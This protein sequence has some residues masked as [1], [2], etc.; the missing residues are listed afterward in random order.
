MKT[1]QPV[2]TDILQIFS[3]ETLKKLDAE[4]FV[5]PAVGNWGPDRVVTLRAQDT[6]VK[7][8]W[9]G[10]CSSFATVAAMENKLGG[11]V[12]LSE[13]S[14]WDLYG[15][16]STEQAL[17]TARIQFVMEEQYWPQHQQYLDPRY[18]GKGR[19]QINGIT[20][21]ERRYLEVLAAIDGG[22]PCVVALS[23]PTDLYNGLPQVEATSGFLRRSG[24]AICVSG[25]K[26]ENGRAYFYVKNS[27][28]TRTGDNG[29]Q[30]VAFDLF[31]QRNVYAVFWVITNVFDRGPQR[32]ANTDQE[33]LM[34]DVESVF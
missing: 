7:S 24:H 11:T 30:Y 22:H 10:T 15:V 32:K 13:R 34:T 6:S 9:D 20:Y 12:E 26:V 27:W 19:Y 25:Y 16:Y 5:V 21:L 3:E 8:Q 1:F 31:N 2:L 33:Y 23:T 14:L 29:Y 17:N 18:R 4:N 28:G